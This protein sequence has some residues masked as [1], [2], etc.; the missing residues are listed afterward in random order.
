MLNENMK[1]IRKSKRAFAARSGGQAECGAP[2]DFKM[3]TRFVGSRCRYVDFHIR[4]AWNAGQHFIGRND[5]GKQKL[6]A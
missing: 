1:V 2:N 4:S 5:Y 6:T 3:G